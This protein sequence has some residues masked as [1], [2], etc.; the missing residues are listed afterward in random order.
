MK[1]L[2]NKKAL[3]TGM[4][5]QDGSYLAEFL[6]FKGYEVHGIIRRA[7]TFNT[8]RINHIYVD[9]MT[10]TPNYFSIMATFQIRSKSV[11]SLW[12]ILQQNSPD[13]FVLGTGQSHSVKE[14][15]ID[16]FSY[17]GLDWKKHIKID[18][19][20]FRPT[21]VAELIADPTKAKKKLKWQPRVRFKELVKLMIDNDLRIAEKEV[22]LRNMPNQ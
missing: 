12:K 22:Y 18:P 3:I 16:A 21:E 8:E 6:F 1:Q 9:P 2:I 4:T 5:G 19:R 20:Y 10:Q 13:D 14:F 7:S 11:I 17:A 15:V